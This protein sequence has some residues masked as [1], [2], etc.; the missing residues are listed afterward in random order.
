[1][2]KRWEIG[3]AAKIRRDDAVGG[4]L[5]LS[6]TY[7]CKFN[8]PERVL[9]ARVS[10][11]PTRSANPLDPHRHMTYKGIPAWPR[12]LRRYREFAVLRDRDQRNG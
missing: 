6:V 4:Y 5:V 2:T 10:A 8:Q 7:S 11:R 9:E 12:T 1:V 3:A